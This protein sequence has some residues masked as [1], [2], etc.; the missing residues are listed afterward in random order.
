MSGCWVEIMARARPVTRVGRVGSGFVFLVIVFGLSQVGSDYFLSSGEN[1]GPRPTRRTVG[2]GRVGSSF[3][4]WVGSGLSGRVAH[5]QVY[6]LLVQY[7]RN[8]MYIV[9]ILQ[10]CTTTPPPQNK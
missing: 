2:S 3:F 1:F 4:R 5:D 7:Y 6:I 10:R 8:K 9:Y